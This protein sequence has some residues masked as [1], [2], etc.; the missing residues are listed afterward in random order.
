MTPIVLDVGQCN[1]DHSSISQLLK[2][3]FNASVD[4]AYRADEAI[5]LASEKEYDLILINR[6]L[7]ADGSEGLPI[8]D[9]LKSSPATQSVPVMLVSN[10]ADSQA[11]AV[12][13]GA[14]PG[15]GKSSLRDPATVERLRPF[16]EK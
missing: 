16:L 4:R 8:L 7:D 2:R 10:Y 9:Q 11:D 13:R 12:T 1:P 5:R 14:E 6:I 3:H 15:F